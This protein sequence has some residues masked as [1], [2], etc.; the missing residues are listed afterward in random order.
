M[1]LQPLLADLGGGGERALL[2]ETR[3]VHAKFVDHPH[4]EDVNVEG[5][6]YM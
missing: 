3:K 4:V 1:R 6:C 2:Y 5:A